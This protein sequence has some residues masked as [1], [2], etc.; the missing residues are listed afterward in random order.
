MK[1]VLEGVLKG[2]IAVMI[3]Y[4]IILAA[5]YPYHVRSANDFYSYEVQIDRIRESKKP[6]SDHEKA[7]LLVIVIEQNRWL[8]NAKN[9]NKESL[10]DWMIPDGVEKLEYLIVP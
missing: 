4:A 8:M 1:H 2:I 10:T 3:L 9:K 5:V 6:F 7:V